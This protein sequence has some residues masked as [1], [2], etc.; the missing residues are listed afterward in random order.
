MSEQTVKVCDACG[1]NVEYTGHRGFLDAHGRA[2]VKRGASAVDATHHVCPTHHSLVWVIGPYS[3][4]RACG[5][6]NCTAGK[7]GKPW[8]YC[9]PR[10]EYAERPTQEQRTEH[11][12]QTTQAAV[13]PQPEIEVSTAVQLNPATNPAAS[14]AIKA[15]LAALT[16][17]APAFDE[18]KMRA[19]VESTVNNAVDAK[20]ASTTRT[21]VIE[22]AAEVKVEIDHPHPYLSRVIKLVNAGLPVYLWGPAGGGKTTAGMQVARALNRESEIDTLDPSTFRSMVQGYC[23]P[24]GEPVHTSFTRCWTSG[25]VYIGDEAD[26]GPGHVQTLF[27][28]A[29]ANGHAPLAWGNVARNE[30][31]AFI[32]TGNTPGRPTREFPDRKPMSAAF[33]DRL[34]FVHWPL[35]EQA[36]RAW[37]GVG[38]KAKAIKCPVPRE[39]A[40]DAWVDFVQRLR[41]WCTTNAPTIMITP[42]ASIVGLKAL[43]AGESPEQVADGLIFRGADSELRSKALNAVKLP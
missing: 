4:F 38:G 20:L 42:R 15:L 29:L 21:L 3:A 13:N 41:E 14:E 1:M 35:D 7:R 32:A 9:A 43:A 25:K 11:E 34:Y 37:S 10:G 31:F 5:E 19:I 18:G 27:N 12:A 28:S 24:T 8:R 6:R 16:P 2:C 17:T 23:T 39:I 40:A 26:N 33:A 22:Q 30:S 36:E